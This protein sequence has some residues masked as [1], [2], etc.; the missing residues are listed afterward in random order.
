MSPHKQKDPG[1][2]A[3]IGV[4]SAPVCQVG[5]DPSFL[6]FPVNW[7]VGAST[8]KD[9]GTCISPGGTHSGGNLSKTV[10]GARTG[11]CLI[12]HLSAD[13]SNDAS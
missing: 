12:T 4:R 6:A 13:S 9:C 2:A 1:E 8:W 7:D 3:G 11:T 5:V 10:L